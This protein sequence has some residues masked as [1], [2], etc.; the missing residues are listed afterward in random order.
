[1]TKMVTSLSTILVCLCAGGVARANPTAASH[2]RHTEVRNLL[3]EVRAARGAITRGEGAAAEDLVRDAIKLDDALAARH[4][5]AVLLTESGVIEEVGPVK[6]APVATSYDRFAGRERLDLQATKTDLVRAH[7]ALRASDMASAEKDL[8]K[9]ED[10]V[11][12]Q[13]RISPE[14]R[15]LAAENL[16]FAIREV[17]AGKWQAAKTDLDAVIHDI[18][19]MTSEK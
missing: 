5:F 16:R 7:A 18:S 17:E 2:R 6:G 8:E 1:M 9:V 3:S 4:R 14:P 13:T 11:S 10:A 15:R 12:F 19:A